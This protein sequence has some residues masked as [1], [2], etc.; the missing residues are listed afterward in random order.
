VGRSWS[1]VQQ[2][3]EQKAQFE[4]LFSDGAG[5]FV[6]PPSQEFSDMDVIDGERSSAVPL[7]DQVISDT[8]VASIWVRRKRFEASLLETAAVV[9]DAG[10]GLFSVVVGEAKHIS[11]FKAVHA[12]YF[13]IRNRS[14]ISAVRYEDSQ[15]RAT[16]TPYK[17]SK[18][19][20]CA[21]VFLTARRALKGSP[22]LWRVWLAF[23][24]QGLG[25]NVQHIPVEAM[26][27]ITE[28]LGNAFISA[29]LSPVGNYFSRSSKKFNEARAAK[30]RLAA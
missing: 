28:L 21:D 2:G 27:Q 3:L 30:I 5:E 26:K 7:T 18:I 20:F 6:L 24:Y 9:V 8:P 17:P 10:D 15:N 22:K 13:N 19:D 25:Q 1:T 29:G 14:A 12:A 4:S 16:L 23:F 11:A